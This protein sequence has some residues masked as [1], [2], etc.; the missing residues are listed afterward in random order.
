MKFFIGFISLSIALACNNTGQ[1]SSS[2]STEP[3]NQIDS[4]SYAIGQDL[5]SNF[6]RNEIEI[7]YEAFYQGL[8]SAANGQELALTPDEQ[9]ALMIRLQQE[10]QAKQMAQA[11]QN[12]RQQMPQSKVKTGDIAPE[13]SLPTPEGE[14][15]NLSDLRGKVVLVDFWASWCKPCR[16]ENPR[17]VAMY[18]KYKDQ[19]FEIY[20]VSLDRTRDA[21]LKAIEQDGLTWHH[22]SDLK[23]WQ[24]AAAQTYGVRGIPYTV[25]LDKEGKIVAESLRGQALEEKV[26]SLL[27]AN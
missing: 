21:W 13:I 14:I 27:A 11:P 9:K 19:G 5:G 25:L 10:I 17:V 24:S 16:I 18:N 15:M 8:M 2:S 23:F 7:N 20:G 6:S 3:E 22:V 4:I 1:L 26:A 12:P